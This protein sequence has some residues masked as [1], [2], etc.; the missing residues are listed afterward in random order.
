MTIGWAT[1]GPIW[2]RDIFQV[3]VRPTR[4]TF[5]LMEKAED[6]TVCFLPSK[7]R[8]ELAICGTRSGKTVDKSEICGFTLKP[9]I[10]VSAPYVQESLFH[11]ECRIVH[12]HRLDPET[13]SPGIIKK[14][15]P[16]RD[17][18]MVYYGEILGLYRP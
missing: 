18:H 2:G 11:Y 10:S 12:K 6:F 14:Y 8:K 13:L 9:G 15:Y 4:Y 7:F 3:Y 1:L 5:G 17:F 16:G